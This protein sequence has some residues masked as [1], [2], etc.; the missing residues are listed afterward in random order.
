MATGHE[1]R[2]ILQTLADVKELEQELDKLSQAWRSGNVQALYQTGIATMIEDYP[3]VYQTL[4]VERNRNWLPRIETLI[5]QPEK[6]LILVG[7][8]HLVGPDGLL[9]QLKSKGYQVNQYKPTI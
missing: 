9:E 6:K 4:M 2:F 7:A 8:L 1:S 5:Q 3:Q